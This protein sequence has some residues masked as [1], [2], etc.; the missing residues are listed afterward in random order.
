MR[1]NLG[2]SNYL[3]LSDQY[4]AVITFG[5]SINPIPTRGADYAHH[6]TA[7][8]P[9]FKNLTVSLQCYAF[10]KE[11]IPIATSQQPIILDSLVDFWI[12]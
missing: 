10:S 8:P 7:C 9:G 3:Y 1:H 4:N 11:N 2:H 6:I 12:R 5:S